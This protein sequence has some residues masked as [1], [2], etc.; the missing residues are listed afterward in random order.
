MTRPQRLDPLARGEL[1]GDLVLHAVRANEI[2]PDGGGRAQRDLLCRDRD[3]QRLERLRVQRRPKAGESVD[4]RPEHRLVRSPRP[5]RVE[6]EPDAEQPSDPLRGLVAPGLDRDP[7][8]RS[9]H[10]YL[11]ACDDPVQPALVQ[12]R[13]PVRPEVAEAD[14]RKCEVV[15]GW[16]LE[17][18]AD[19]GYAPSRTSDS[20]GRAARISIAWLQPSGTTQAGSP[21]RVTCSGRRPRAVWR[22]SA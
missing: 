10:A 1:P 2:S 20:S 15:G 17:Q 22:A 6:V 18:Q 19:G 21:S 11:A 7:A 8:L 9:G 4:D 13:R 5:E 16:D 12:D 14:G 3:H